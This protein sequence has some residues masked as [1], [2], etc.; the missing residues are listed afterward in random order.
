MTAAFT[1]DNIDRL[2]AVPLD[3]PRGWEVRFRSANAGLHHQLYVNGRLA[4]FTDSPRQRTFLLPEQPAPARLCVAAVAAA[5]RRTDFARWLPAEAVPPWVFRAD[6]IQDLKHPPGTRVELL[7]DHASGELD[8]APLA[9]R[10]LWPASSPRWGFGESAFARGG[11]G[12][13]GVGAPG[14]GRGAFGAGPFGMNAETV[15]LAAAL[16]EPGT[17]RVV[18]RTVAPDGRTADADPIAFEASPPPAPATGLTAI[19]WDPQT[20]TLTLRIEES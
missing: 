8:E 7:T 9:V 13:G 11:F 12:Y 5:E 10:D 14:L 20:Q 2:Q 19:A 15:R 6:V 18:L 17:H 4:D 1:T 3:P 16:A